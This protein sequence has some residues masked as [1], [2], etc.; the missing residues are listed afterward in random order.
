MQLYHVLLHVHET[1]KL[2]K[3]HRG[4]N[5]SLQS[6]ENKNK[7][8]QLI[9]TC[10]LVVTVEKCT[11]CTKLTTKANFSDECNVIGNG[12]FQETEMRG[13]K[14][15]RL[16]IFQLLQPISTSMGPK[17]RQINQERS[18]LKECKLK[19]TGCTGRIHNTI[20][21]FIRYVRVDGMQIISN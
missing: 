21:I 2:K 20:F 19:V 14:K 12:K 8:P 4:L 1:R 16:I 6:T 7:K 11:Y 17:T 13:E 3:V 15:T 5:R 9:L 18:N 10:F